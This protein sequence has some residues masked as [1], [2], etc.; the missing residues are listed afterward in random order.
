MNNNSI[1]INP[2]RIYKKIEIR[3]LFKQ[4]EKEEIASHFSK[5]EIKLIKSLKIEATSPEKER[6]LN[7]LLRL[8]NL[9]FEQVDDFL[10]IYEKHFSKDDDPIRDQM[11]FRLG[12]NQFY[13]TPYAEHDQS[14]IGC[15]TKDELVK[16][17]ARTFYYF[18]DITDDE[19]NYDFEYKVYYKEN[20]LREYLRQKEE[21][22]KLTKIKFIE[23][24]ATNFYVD[25]KQVQKVKDA[26][27]QLREQKLYY[28]DNN[29]II[30]PNFSYSEEVMEQIAILSKLSKVS[31]DMIIAIFDYKR[32]NFELAK[33]TYK[34]KT[35]IN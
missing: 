32:D 7:D 21:N 30:S 13:L 33:S 17:Y 23:S 34:L 11:F 24:K 19:E 1:V 18:Q 12:Q 28:F 29:L 35:E 4:L 10:T 26:V 5:S 8:F 9:T 14:I 6:E 2:I 31:P 20:V 16:Q 25:S 27:D 3:S 15:I 22:K